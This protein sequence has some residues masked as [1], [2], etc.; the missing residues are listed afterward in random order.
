MAILFA[1][2]QEFFGGEGNNAAVVPAPH[3]FQFRLQHRQFTPPDR[4]RVARKDSSVNHGSLPIAKL[5]R[6]RF[7]QRAREVDASTPLAT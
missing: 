4:F 3:D 6:N 1:T 7:A 5:P 2:N